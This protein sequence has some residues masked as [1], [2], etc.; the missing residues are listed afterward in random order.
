M[1]YCNWGQRQ[2]GK[3]YSVMKVYGSYKFDLV[4]EVREGFFEKI[5]IEMILER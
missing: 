4:R 3:V 2:D 1:Y 5:S